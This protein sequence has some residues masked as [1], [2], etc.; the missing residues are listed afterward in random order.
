MNH[1]IPE[2]KDTDPRFRWH[3]EDYYKTDA[4]WEAAYTE[5]EASISEMAAFSG[6][7]ADSAETLLSCLQEGKVIRPPTQF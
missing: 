6:R 5:L 1:S 4:D 2:R 7:L 3:I